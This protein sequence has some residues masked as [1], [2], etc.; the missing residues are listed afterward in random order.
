MNLSRRQWRTVKPGKLQ[1]MGFKD[2][3]MNERL[4]NKFLYNVVLVSA[5]HQHE[6][7]IG[8]HMS[9]PP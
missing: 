9:L 7:A 2:S 3:D 5:I 8:V 4:N 6:S 1:S